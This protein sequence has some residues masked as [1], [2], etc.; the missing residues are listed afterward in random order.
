MRSVII[1]GI[2]AF[3]LVVAG[4]VG[5]TWYAQSSAAIAAIEGFIA[6][7]KKGGADISYQSIESSGFPTELNITIKNPRIKGDVAQSLKLLSALAPKTPINIPHIQ[8]WDED[9]ALNGDILLNVN[10]L[11]DHYMMRINGNIQVNHNVNGEN[12]SFINQSSGATYCSIHLKRGNLFSDLWDFSGIIRAPEA[13]LEDFRMFDCSHPAAALTSADGNTILFQND[14]ARFYI[15]NHPKGRNLEF[16]IF[17]NFPNME[18]TQQG[19]D[20]YGKL[21]NAIAN[22]HYSHPT[23][24]AK[25]G[26]QNLNLDFLYKGPKKILRPQNPNIEVNLSQ[27]NIANDAY[28]SSL[29]FYF[30]NNTDKKSNNRNLVISTR[31]ESNFTPIYDELIRDMISGSINELYTRPELRTPEMQQYINLYNQ[32]EMYSIIAPAIPEFSSLQKAVFSLDA[33]YNGLPEFTSGELLVND[34]QLT[35]E[36]YGIRAVGTGKQKLRAMPT[37]QVNISCNNCVNMIDD[38]IAYAARLQKTLT[39]FS[40]EIAPML[41]VSPKLRDRLI[42]FLVDIAGPDKVNLTYDITADSQVGYTINGEPFDNIV[43]KYYQ[44]VAPAMA[45]NKRNV[46][47]NTKR[48]TPKPSRRIRNKHNVYRD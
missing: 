5:I 46:T 32:D 7:A 39:Y 1:V 47:A 22:D 24:L 34:L 18:F 16:R 26:K 6:K 25:Y 13:Y 36:P 38:I 2:L 33:K 40:P 43:E 41:S 28:Q 30:L 23:D 20:V 3:I 29:K 15:S 44:L 45:Q 10:A 48:I 35:F 37:G 14:P 8:Q 27:F 42:R 4:G 21:V 19:S 9:I 12:I 11:S 17:M 31:A